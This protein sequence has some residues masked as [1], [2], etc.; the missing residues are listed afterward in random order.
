MICTVC[1]AYLPAKSRSAA[2]SFPAHDARRAALPAGWPGQRAPA[3]TH[4]R[5]AMVANSMLIRSVS[6]AQVATRPRTSTEAISTYS[7]RSVVLSSFDRYPNSHDVHFIARFSWRMCRAEW[8]WGPRCFVVN[9]SLSREWGLRDN[10]SSGSGAAGPYGTPER[11]CRASS[12]TRGSAAR[13][14]FPLSG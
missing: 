11:D 6:V 7:T 12:V 13:L 3:E 2:R 14:N 5:L 1:Y 9:V 10:R 4:M 8:V